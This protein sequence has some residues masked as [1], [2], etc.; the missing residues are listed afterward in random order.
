MSRTV[1]ESLSYGRAA[2]LDAIDVEVL[3]SHVLGKG[4]TY[5][6]AWPEKELTG[7]QWAAF[8]ELLNRRKAGE[9][10]AY[11]TGVREF[12]SLPIQTEPST[13]IPRPD[14]EVLV[15]AV[16]EQKGQEPLRC[17]DL[18]TGT[19]AIALAI[20][21]ERP[22]WQVRGVDR[23]S[24]AVDLAMRNASSLNLDVSFYHGSWC[25]P[26][27]DECFDVIVSN[28]PYIDAEDPHLVEGDVRF[29]PRSA[30]VA[31]EQGLAD[32]REILV[33][34]RLCLASEGLLFIEH[35]WQQANDVQS[36]FLA[37]GYTDVRTYRDYGGNDR[38]TCGKLASVNE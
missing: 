16:L 9:P 37:H 10:V 32:I 36:L 6:I 23:V 15:E 3:L 31:D 30:L 29:E 18:G 5:L 24:S 26:V 21:S 22:G 12:W 19:G 14:T 27:M 17:L 1:C 4:R 38:V 7:D 28:P 13:L 20:K 34:A 33:Q 11:L 8:E 25:E 35:G 2:A